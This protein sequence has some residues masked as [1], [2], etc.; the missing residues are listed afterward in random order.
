M[1]F[2]ANPSSTSFWCFVINFLYIGRQ[3]ALSEL[4]SPDLPG[5]R[6]AGIAGMTAPLFVV[7]D[8]GWA[9]GGLP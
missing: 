7:G 2:P 9:E 6:L 1:S 4:N 5:V 8:E 3:S